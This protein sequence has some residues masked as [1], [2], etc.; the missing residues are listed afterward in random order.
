MFVIVHFV[1]KVGSV[2][3]DAQAFRFSSLLSLCH[4]PNVFKG[5]YIIMSKYTSPS[6]F[7]DK[8]I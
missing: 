2:V 5:L 3:C 1:G 4:W 8:D 6:K 7:L